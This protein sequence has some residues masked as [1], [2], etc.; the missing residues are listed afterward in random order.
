MRRDDGILFGHKMGWICDSICIIVRFLFLVG[1]RG[2]PSFLAYLHASKSS[3]YHT[4]IG[5]GSFIKAATQ[6]DTF[7]PAHVPPD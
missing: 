1:G 4:N 7:S 5:V 3:Q 2:F 6:L